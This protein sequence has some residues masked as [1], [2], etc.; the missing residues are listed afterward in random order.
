M[1][2]FNSLTKTKK[3]IRSQKMD[4]KG[5]SPFVP[6]PFVPHGFAP[7]FFCKFSMNAI[8]YNHAEYFDAPPF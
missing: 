8:I 7:L 6:S 3:S 5:T 4:K 2:L 1:L